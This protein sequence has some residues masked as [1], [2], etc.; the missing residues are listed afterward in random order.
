MNIWFYTFASQPL[1]KAEIFKLIENASEEEL[2]KDVDFHTKNLIKHG[3]MF[4][5]SPLHQKAVDYT[6][7]EDMK[8]RGFIK[9]AVKNNDKRV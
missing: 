6:W 5:F 4:C 8:R 1:C 7:L 3:D 9:K 2:K